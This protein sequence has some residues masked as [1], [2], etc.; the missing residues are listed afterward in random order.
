MINLK[1]T[2]KKTTPE[3]KICKKGSAALYV[4]QKKDTSY[5]EDRVEAQPKQSSKK[6]KKIKSEDIVRDLWDNIE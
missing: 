5:L 1:N 2:V 4:I 6:K 3:L